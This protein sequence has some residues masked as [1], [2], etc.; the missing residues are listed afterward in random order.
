MPTPEHTAPILL[1]P[2]TISNEYINFVATF[3]LL[4]PIPHGL[5]SCLVQNKRCVNYFQVF[6]VQQSSTFTVE[7]ASS[8]QTEALCFGSFSSLCL[9]HESRTYWKQAMKQPHWTVAQSCKLMVVVVVLPLCLPSFSCVCLCVREWSC[10]FNRRSP[11][12]T[13]LC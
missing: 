9:F 7:M 8:L 6:W 13:I 3:E 10:V 5:L 11:V 1:P 12:L 4:N 2:P